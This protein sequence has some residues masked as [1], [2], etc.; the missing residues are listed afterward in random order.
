MPGNQNPADLLSRGVTAYQFR[1]SGLWHFGQPLLTDRWPD[2]NVMATCINTKD[3]ETVT[4]VSF[5]SNAVFD[6]IYM[7]NSYNKTIRV[8]V[9]VLRFITNLNPI[10]LVQ[11]A[12]G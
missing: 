8:I 3:K 7:C 12:Y 4:T 11:F 6:P 1:K 2:Q 5:Q 9:Y 10:N